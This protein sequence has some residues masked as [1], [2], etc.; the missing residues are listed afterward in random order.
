[1]LAPKSRPSKTEQYLTDEAWTAFDAAFLEDP[2]AIPKPKPRVVED[3]LR[4]PV[5]TEH[6]RGIEEDLGVLSISRAKF[7]INLDVCFDVSDK[8]KYFQSQNH[9]YFVG[10]RDATTI[11]NLFGTLWLENHEWLIH[12]GYSLERVQQVKR[13]EITLLVKEGSELM[14]THCWTIKGDFAGQNQC[15]SWKDFLYHAERWGRGK[16]LDQLRMIEQRNRRKRLM[17]VNDDFGNL[18]DHTG[19]YWREGGRSIHAQVDAKIVLHF[20]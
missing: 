17:C 14:N 19:N 16:A 3:K 6:K 4:M 7:V 18:Y 20:D 10:G 5:S 9:H 15:K 12:N 11:K 2:T 13:M 1:M 8:P